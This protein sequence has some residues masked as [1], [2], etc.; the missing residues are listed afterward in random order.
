LAGYIVCG[1]VG[2]FAYKGSIVDYEALVNASDLLAHR[3]PDEG[4]WWMDGPFFM[5]HRRLS[6]I[7]LE[8]GSQ[9]MGT[10]DGRYV[11]VFNGEIYN[12]LELR[13]E[14]A[15]RGVEFNTLSDTEVLLQGYR[16]WGTDLPRHLV[17]M[18]AFAIADRLDTSLFLARDRF[19]EKPL[20][21]A[22][23]DDG[24]TFASELRAIAALPGFRTELDH[25]SLGQ[26]LCLNYV[27]G[28]HT[29]LKSVRRLLPGTWRRFSLGTRDGGV[30]WRPPLASTEATGGSAAVDS[31]EEL[32]LR[33]DRS[34]RIALRSDVPVTLFLSGGIDSSIIAESA[35]RQGHLKHAYCLEFPEEG[36]SEMVNAA[37]VAA[38]LGLELRRVGLTADVLSDFYDVVEHADDPLADSS[39]LAVWALSKAVARDYKVAVSG[40]GGDEV[41]A[42]YLTYK[43]TKLHQLL[44][45][46]TSPAFR[47]HLASAARFLPVRDGK[48]S[49]SYKLMRFIRAAHLTSGEAHFSWN[50]AWLPADAARLMVGDAELAGLS[51]TLQSLARRHEL[52][53][54]FDL[55]ALQRADATDYLPNDI[56]TKVDRMTMAHGLESRA[57]LLIPDIA[58]FGLALPDRLKLTTFGQPKQ[59]LRRL[60]THIYGPEIGAAKKQG[61]SI[62]V[63]RWIRGPM[64]EIV[65]ELLS[66]PSLERLEVID[67][68]QALNAKARHMEGKAQLGFELWGL[69]VL[70][71]WHRVRIQRRPPAMNR[72]A[73]TR[74]IVLPSPQRC[75][76]N[77]E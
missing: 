11:V 2:R 30:Y 35:V 54:E 7:D 65:E 6:I 12:Y 23:D 40:D 73:S 41:F 32:K 20:F 63:H 39:A 25:E 31:L 44:T 10:T 46:Y 13:Q 71:A 24:V 64:R 56:L 51:E 59:I 15:R 16:Y 55:A 36:F 28:E 14:L 53:N 75:Q 66:R 29:L 61:F 21:L 26:Y 43:A 22:E 67:V 76:S 52:G 70:V 8:L 69:M 5:G 34:V 68:H 42:G 19:G 58:E 18:F 33:I 49:L 57:P 45:K 74:R 3:G 62:P 60:A 1:I 38:K 9:P 4:T 72:T 37:K 50:G 47:K 48:V 27:P 77:V 17:G